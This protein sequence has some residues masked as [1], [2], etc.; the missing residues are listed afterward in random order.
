MFFVKGPIPSSSSSSSPWNLQH[1]ELASLDV[2][3]GDVADTI[4]KQAMKV[5]TL[6]NEVSIDIEYK[7]CLPKGG[8]RFAFVC[9]ETQM[10]SGGRMG[11]MVTI[12]NEDMELLCVSRQVV[13]VL[14]AARRFGGGKKITLPSR[15]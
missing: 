2:D 3:L 11:I 7:R 12:C 15:M 14:E 13:L 1:P 4:S 6:D 8:Q 10:L 9:Y 5:L